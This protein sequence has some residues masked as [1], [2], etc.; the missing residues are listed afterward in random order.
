[1][2]LNFF[3]NPNSRINILI[4]S[5]WDNK[6]KELSFLSAQKSTFIGQTTL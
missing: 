4:I 5:H 3:K 1:M 6:I 2:G